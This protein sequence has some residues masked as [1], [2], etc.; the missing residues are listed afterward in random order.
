[1]SEYEVC[2]INEDEIQTKL[3]DKDFWHEKE[4]TT[5]VLDNDS[6]QMV[7]KTQKTRTKYRRRVPTTEK[8][9]KLPGDRALNPQSDTTE[10]QN[11]GQN[12]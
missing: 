5:M 10:E 6:G 7:E 4:T 9:C 8:Y 2:I 3:A 1:M 12:G 11:N